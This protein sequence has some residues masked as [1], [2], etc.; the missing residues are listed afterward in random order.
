M[1]IVLLDGAFANQMTQYIFAR[2]LQEETTDAVFL[3][4]L[5]FHVRHT[6]FCESAAPIEKHHYQLD[7]LPNIKKIPRMSEYFDQDVWQEIIRRSSEMGPLDCGSHLPQI[8]KDNGLE[9]FMIAEAPVYKFDGM[10]ARMP[11]YYC[12]PEMLAAQGNV[13]Y[14]GWFTNGGWF[15][16]HEKALR[17]ELALP[18]LKSA[19]DLNMA[20]EI[21]QSFSIGVHVRCGGGFKASGNA[22]PAEYYKKQIENICN[23]LKS[24]KNT[25]PRKPHIYI[26]ADDI[27][28]CKDN[29][30][31]FGLDKVP[32]PVTFGQQDRGPDDNQN[33][34][35]LLSM[36][37]VT[38]LNNSVYG[39][40]AA[41]LNSKPNKAVVNPVKTRGVF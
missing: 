22:L 35:K 11:Y 2:C 31:E 37:D 16:R 4:D 14:Y 23:Q 6:D 30:S 1:K 19:A 5:Y 12:I 40:M 21:E 34:M 38:I 36:C 33:D 15:M 9:F 26:F 7:K 27:A 29:F 3:D 28:W 17:H 41:L 39:Y 24:M 13:Y 18:P 8:L 25:L 20:K 32:Y 10:V